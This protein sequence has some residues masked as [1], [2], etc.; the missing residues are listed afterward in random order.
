MNRKKAEKLIRRKIARA[1]PC[2]FCGK[3][4]EIIADCDTEFSNWGSWGHYVYRKPCCRPTH[5][6]QTDLFFT[7]NW[8][9]P[10]YSLWWYMVCRVVDEWNTRLG[11]NNLYQ[12]EYEMKDNNQV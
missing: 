5:T 9:K 10:N 11:E 1:K 7:N 8:R 2:P 6:G 4:P 12:K 3:I